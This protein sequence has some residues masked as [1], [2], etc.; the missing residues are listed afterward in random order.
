MTR[1]VSECAL[2]LCSP[3]QPFADDAIVANAVTATHSSSSSYPSLS[4]PP[5]SS[6]TSPQRSSVHSPSNLVTGYTSCCRGCRD[7]SGR[8]LPMGGAEQK[9]ISS[10]GLG[11]GIFAMTR[12][13]HSK[14]TSILS[15]YCLIG[16]NPKLYST[17]LTAHPV[18]CS[19]G[20]ST[21]TY[22]H[23]LRLHFFQYGPYSVLN[24][25]DRRRRRIQTRHE[26]RHISQ[27]PE[28]N[29]EGCSS[30]RRGHG[31]ILVVQF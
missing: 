22:T 8:A 20:R 11:I 2:L 3:A 13:F 9:R 23:I 7:W 1:L 21:S 5:S 17:S 15:R 26:I 30:R 28:M 14:A 24:R 19:T 12:S 31:V 27:C 4:S 16:Q 18:P 6:C 10:C 29:A 25:P